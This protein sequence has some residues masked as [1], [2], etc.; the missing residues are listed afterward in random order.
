MKCSILFV[1]LSLSWAAV[2]GQEETDTTTTASYTIEV[3]SDNPEIGTADAY[4]MSGTGNSC[5]ATFSAGSIFMIE[6][7]PIMETAY[8]V[9]WSDGDTNSKRQITLTQDTVLVG[10]FGAKAGISDKQPNALQMSPNPAR[11]RVSL[12]A[13]S[14]ILTLECMDAA[15][16]L[17]GRY[18]PCTQTYSLDLS[19][20]PRGLYLIRVATAKGVV[21]KKLVVL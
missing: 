9:G 15:G 6:A 19:G 2:F 4:F 17:A 12:S 18:E 21:R 14:P 10:Y 8:F 11:E 3:Y 1:F 7:V 13:E 20:W 16:R 5:F